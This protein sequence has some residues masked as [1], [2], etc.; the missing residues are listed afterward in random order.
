MHTKALPLRLLQAA[1]AAAGLAV[2]ILAAGCS[3]GPSDEMTSAVVSGEKAVAM[4]GQDAFFG[5]RIA[6]KVTLSRGIGHGIKR[7]HEKGDSSYED[8]ADNEHKVLVGSPLPPVTLHLILTNNGAGE[9]A[10]T[11]DDFESDMGNFVLDPE[12]L[13]LAPGQ[14]A[15][16][17]PMVS[18]LGVS[19]DSIDFKVTLKIGKNR[20]SRTFPV[21]ILPATAR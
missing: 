19:S 2:A 8:Y 1:L 10:V 21:R 14:T 6:V 17:T 18:Q 13:T 15:E 9:A 5:G 16:P 7:S 20:E 11:M 4:E 12:T 3:H